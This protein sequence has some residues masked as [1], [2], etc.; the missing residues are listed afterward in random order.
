[1]QL[2]RGLIYILRSGDEHLP[3]AYRNIQYL[4]DT[5]TNRMHRMFHQQMIFDKSDCDFMFPVV[6]ALR[7][8]GTAVTENTKFTIDRKTKPEMIPRTIGQNVITSWCV[9]CGTSECA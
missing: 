8:C 2:H 7:S 5:V 3:V 9:F 6:K 4:C 1:M